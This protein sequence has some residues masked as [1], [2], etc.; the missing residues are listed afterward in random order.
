MN[1][2]KL[3]RPRYLVCMCH[4]RL[5]RLHRQRW[6]RC[7]QLRPSHHHHHR[8]W[9]S[10]LNRTIQMIPQGPY[11]P[12]I[13]QGASRSSVRPTQ[14]C[15][16]AYQPTCTSGHRERQTEDRQS[17]LSQVWIRT[18][19]RGITRHPGQNP[20]ELRLPR[21]RIKRCHKRWFYHRTP[22]TW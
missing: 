15:R 13:I 19:M 22:P 12:L 14:V 2:R 10:K 4:L 20:P 1:S 21:L 8:R 6:L 18:K 3:Y 7:R 5:H 17:K 11:N 9:Q 16:Q